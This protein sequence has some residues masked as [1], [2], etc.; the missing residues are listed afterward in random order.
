MPLIL[1]EVKEITQSAVEQSEKVNTLINYD[2]ISDVAF[3]MCIGLIMFF[4]SKF[5]GIIF[6]WIG[7]II[8]ALCAYTIFMA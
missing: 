1:E 4:F 2:S 5:I 8:I 7:L 6:K 3:L